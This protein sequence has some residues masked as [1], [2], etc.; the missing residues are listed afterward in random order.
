MKL[1]SGSEALSTPD[2]DQRVSLL[3]LNEKSI[4]TDKI[5]ASGRQC[6]AAQIAPG[7]PAELSRRPTEVPIHAASQGT[8]FIALETLEHNA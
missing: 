1:R 8:S 3:R 6:V 4:A 5:F 2:L 7:G